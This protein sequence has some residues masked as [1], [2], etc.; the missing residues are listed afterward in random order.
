MLKLQILQALREGWRALLS[1]Q[2]GETII[3]WPGEA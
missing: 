1:L 2:V 3:G